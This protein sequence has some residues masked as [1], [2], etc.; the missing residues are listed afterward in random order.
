MTFNKESEF[1][2]ALIN[3]LKTKGWEENVIKYP[4]EKDLIKNWANI[5]YVIIEK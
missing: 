2:L 1:E 4:T 5:L 3:V